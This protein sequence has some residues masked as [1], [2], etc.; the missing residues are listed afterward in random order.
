MTTHKQ[1]HSSNSNEWYTPEKYIN[2]IYKVMGCLTL[3]P[4]SCEFANEVVGANI[5]YTKQDNGLIKDWYGN[6]FLNPPYGRTKGKSN[7][8]IWSKKLI[9]E[10]ECGNVMQAILLVNAVPGNRWFQPL[11]DYPLCFTDHRIRFYNRNG[12]QRSPTH[13]N[14]FV[15]MGSAQD[16]FAS[17][18]SKF[19]PVIT[20]V[21][22]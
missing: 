6:V 1:I 4:A 21:I 15:Y 17:A 2:A 13:S 9:H 16:R 7:A 12:V 19:G 22:K 10:Y 14:C 11:W 3:D 18:F 20:R 8:E 5:F